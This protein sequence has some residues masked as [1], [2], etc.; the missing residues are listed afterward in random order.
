LKLEIRK[1]STD[2]TSSDSVLCLND[3]KFAFRGKSTVDMGY[4]KFRWEFGDGDVDTLE[5]SEHRYRVPGLYK[6]RFITSYVQFGCSDTVLREIR[7]L[8]SPAK[9]Q[10]NL[11]AKGKSICEGESGYLM[12][13]VYPRYRWYLDDLLLDSTRVVQMGKSGVYKAL[14]YDYNGCSSYMSDTMQIKVNKVPI[15]PEVVGEVKYCVGMKPVALVAKATSGNKLFWYSSISGDTVRYDTPVP[16]TSKSGIVEYYVKQV[17]TEG[18]ESGFSKIIVRVGTIKKPTLKWTNAG[19]FEVDSGYLSYKWYKDNALIANVN[20]RSHRPAL[21]GR[22][23]VKVTN[24]YGCEDSSDSFILVVTALNNVD[25][26]TGYNMQVYPNPIVGQVWVDLGERPGREVTLKVLTPEGREVY[27]TMSRQQVTQ[28]SLPGL[29]SGTYL[30]EAS[31]GVK[32]QRM[33]VVKN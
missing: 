18:C 14:I 15:L 20:G 10:I 4:R 7:V 11:V 32:R 27:R 26:R 9:P 23:M 30:I 22:F 29:V 5:L 3:N 31:E 2:Y 8:E 33:R 19:D 21:T 28:L 24:E 16:S 6:V 17:S 1:P 12:L 13:G 25:L